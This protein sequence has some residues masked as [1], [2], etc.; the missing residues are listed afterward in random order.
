MVHIL[1]FHLY[2]FMGKNEEAEVWEF[3]SLYSHICVSEVS[4][5]VG[6]MAGHSWRCVLNCMVKGTSAMLEKLQEWKNM[7]RTVEFC[8]AEKYC[9][10]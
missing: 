9:E 6:F 2:F 4:C 8:T 10:E 7:F 1:S 5:A 3:F